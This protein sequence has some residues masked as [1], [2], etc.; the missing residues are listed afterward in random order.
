[1]G[2][3]ADPLGELL[4]VRVGRE[5]LQ[6]VVT[7]PKIPAGYRRVQVAV[8]WPAQ[9]DGPSRITPLQ[10]APGQ[11]SAT[12]P[13]RYGARQEVVARKPALADASAAQ[14]ARSPCIRFKV[15]VVW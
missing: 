11:L 3:I 8:A 4:Y 9:R 15:L 14:L 13:S 12:H 6:G 1:V 2:L 7:L 5:R 10:L